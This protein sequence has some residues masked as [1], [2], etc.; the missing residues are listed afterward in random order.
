WRCSCSRCW[1]KTVTA[2]LPAALV[3]AAWWRRGRLD[4]RRDVVPLTPFVAAGVAAGIWS[5]WIE[6][7][8]IGAQGVEFQLTLL[9]RGLIAARAIA[10]YL[11]KLVWPAALT[12]NYARWNVDSGVWWQ[13]LYPLAL[14]V[15][16]VTLWKIRS[17]SRAPLAALLAF[18]A[19]L[20]PTL[21][22]LNV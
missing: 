19:L 14:F 3:I 2:V 4:F 15:A 12:F 11:G 8:I 16:L 1:T 9:Q 20:F 5:A 22:F 21:G 18:C 17:R 6:H 13:Y 10:F 7:S